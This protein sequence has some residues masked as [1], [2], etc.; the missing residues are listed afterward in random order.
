MKINQQ[1]ILPLLVGV[2]MIMSTSCQQKTSDYHLI[3]PA[4]V[5]HIEGSEFNK[6]ELT[7]KAIERIDINTEEVS[8]EQ[9][10]TGQQT[11]KVVPYSSLIY[12]PMGD[13]WVYTVKE[14]HV[15][16]RQV[17]K[18]DFIRGDKAFLSEGP[19]TGTPVVTQGAAELYGTEYEVGH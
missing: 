10:T 6:V 7:E 17:V 5:E 16:V 4:H 8:E 3:H 1:I 19:P 12:S 9:T 14:P 13:V 15:F 2:I 11:V 18:V